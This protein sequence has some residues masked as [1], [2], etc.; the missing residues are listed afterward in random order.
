MFA[1]LVLAAALLIM[2]LRP[3]HVLLRDLMDF[4]LLL[5][6]KFQLTDERLDHGHLAHAR[7]PCPAA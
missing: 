3:R 4:Y 5:R 1:H 6:R 2:S 7:P